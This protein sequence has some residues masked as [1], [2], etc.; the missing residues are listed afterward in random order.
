MARLA[1]A[2]IGTKVDNAQTIGGSG[3]T[4]NAY[5]AGLSIGGDLSRI[6]FCPCSGFGKCGEQRYRDAF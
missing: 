6:G 4:N 2:G 3:D 5:L 1:E